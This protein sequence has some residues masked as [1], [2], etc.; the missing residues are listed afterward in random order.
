ME[1]YDWL[2]EGRVEHLSFM[3]F[4]N[5]FYIAD[6]KLT[7]VDDDLQLQMIVIPTWELMANPQTR[8]IIANYT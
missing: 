1:A 2:N 5:L 4:I 7:L 3:V 6:I 8:V